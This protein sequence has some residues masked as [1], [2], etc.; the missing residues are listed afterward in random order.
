MCVILY[1]CCMLFFHLLYL[2][3][4]VLNCWGLSFET[5]VIPVGPPLAFDPELQRLDLL[6]NPE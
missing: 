2:H 4:P 3:E 5:T 1:C 6:R